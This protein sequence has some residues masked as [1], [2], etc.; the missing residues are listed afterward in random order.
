[1]DPYRDSIEHLTDELKRVDLLIRR[2]L[3]IARDHRSQGNEEYRGLVISEP[4][5]DALLD[6]GEF[7]LQ[8][9]RKQDKNQDNLDAPDRKLEELRKTIDERRE[10]T[11]KTGRHLTLPHVAER[12][13]LS[14]AEVD[15]LLVAMAPELEPRYETLY[16]Y[17]Q[18][19]VTRKRPSVDLALNLICRSEREKLFARRFLAPGAPLIHFHLLEL[20][21]E[22]HD[23][24]A[25]LLRRFLKI[26]D[27]MLRFLLEH[28]P[29]SLALGT[30]VVPRTTIDSLDVDEPTRT[31]L[32]NLV[33]S[34][35]RAGATKTVIR[36]VGSGGPELQAVAAALADAQQR[37]LITVDLAALEN[38]SADVNAL[39]RDVALYDAILAVF[40]T[41]A[42]EAPAAAEEPHR[43]T[44]ARKQFWRALDELPGHAIALGPES[45]FGEVPP[46]LRIWKIELKAPAFE[47]RRQTW[48]AAL[49]GVSG[50]A[51][52]SR[53]ADTFR[54]GAA[55]IRQAVTLGHSLA[56]LRNPSDPAPSMSDLLEAGRA[57]SGSNLRRFATVIQ[58]RYTWSDIVLPDEKRH[59][60]EHISARVKHR[61]TVHY[62]W[63]F[64]DK[65]SRG[66]GLNVLFAG[67]SGV[68]KTMAAEVLANEL[69]LV[70][71][72]IDL[73]SVVSKYI[74]ETEKH[75]AAIFREAEMSQSLLFFDEADSLF[76]KRTEVKDAHDRYANLEV[77]Y[78]LQRIEQYEGLVILA[79]N[80]QRNLDD[81]FLRRMQEVIDFPFPDD[82]LRERIWRQHLPASAPR[83]ANIDYA[84][85]ARQF[86]L[87]GGNIKNAVMTAAY[88]AAGEGKTIGMLHMIRGVRMELQKQGKLVMKSDFG[89][90]FETVQR[91]ADKD[92]M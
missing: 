35:Q 3:A 39:I 32:H 17:L 62:D 56:S 29:T 18:D 52:A 20:L 59:Q 86:K 48:E 40:A 78:L 34:V 91:T 90:Y 55:H 42:P 81:A 88:L 1:M 73:S 84:F 13:G 27:S 26:E 92:V 82:T 31:Q 45:I 69:S 60:L 37:P 83:E 66:K 47:Q 15:L 80:M 65:L 10:L 49:A 87:T 85:L 23:R 22:P 11:A 8:H 7:L 5:I 72:Q 61:R 30:F 24:Q 63:G 68:G 57:L 28:A 16:A 76:G 54:F 71:F 44:Q 19:D 21:E 53:L 79:T 14:A 70:L 33:D 41:E 36:V 4:E 58:P 6:A 64:G 50:D 89:K 74:G 2:A 43:A 12:F 38:T 67:Q 75:L 46:D 77:N 9:W 51:D 25:T